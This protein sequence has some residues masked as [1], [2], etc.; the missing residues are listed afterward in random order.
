[1]TL[2]EIYHGVINLAETAHHLAP[3]LLS[4]PHRNDIGDLSMQDRAGIHRGGVACRDLS[5]AIAD[6][7]TALS[8]DARARI[9]AS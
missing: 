4:Y 2:K 8:P 6:A 7:M 5:H 1:M 3:G 9:A